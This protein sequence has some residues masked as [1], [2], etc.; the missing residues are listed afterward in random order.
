MT[1]QVFDT[2]RRWLGWCPNVQ[3]QVRDKKVR[4]FDGEVVPPGSGSFK[5]RAFHWFGLFQNQITLQTIGTFCI[6]FYMCAGLGGVSHLNLFLVGILA[7]LPF[8]AIVG[9]LYRRIFYEVLHDGPVVL[10]KH[11]DKTWW[12]IT[13]VT[14]AASLCIWTLVFL[15][16]IPG[17]S[18]EMISAFFGGVIAVSF[19]GMLVS[20][21]KW[22]SDTHRQLHYDGLVLELEKEGDT[23]TSLMH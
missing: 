2:I 22:E 5:A 14:V 3:A 16:K 13:G 21:W 10:Q 18:L 6:G 12:I 15:G 17:F 4:S 8:S 7:G 23:C 9:F 11:Y 20:V 19:F 1:G